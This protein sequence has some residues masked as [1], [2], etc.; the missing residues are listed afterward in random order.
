MELDYGKQGG[1]VRP[2]GTARASGDAPAGSQAPYSS[3]GALL[4]GDETSLERVV[5][6]TCEQGEG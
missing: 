2:G 3:L 6:G 5:K 1:L 4:E